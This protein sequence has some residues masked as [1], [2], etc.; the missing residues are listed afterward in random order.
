[1]PLT[2]DLANSSGFSIAI[3]DS[4]GNSEIVEGEAALQL[5]QSY[6]GIDSS[7]NIQLQDG[8][9]QVQQHVLLQPHNFILQQPS[10]T[11]DFLTVPDQ[12]PTSTNSALH[13]FPPPSASSQVHAKNH[14]VEQLGR[15]NDSVVASLKRKALSN[16]K[17]NQKSSGGRNQKK[18]GDSNKKNKSASSKTADKNNTSK[19]VVPNLGRQSSEQQFNLQ[20][21]D[22]ILKQH[23]QPTN[24]NTSNNSED[25]GSN[26]FS[27]SDL[28]ASTDGDHSDGGLLTSG[29]DAVFLDQG[30]LILQPDLSENFM[31][32]S[33]NFISSGVVSSDCQTNSA[34][35]QPMEILLDQD[36]L[37]SQSSLTSALA[38]SQVAGMDS[39]TISLPRNFMFD[40]S[41]PQLV[42]LSGNKDGNRQ[43]MLQFATIPQV[44]E[45]VSCRV[46][47]IN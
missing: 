27:A 37:H 45:V 14:D 30:Y 10:F 16:K 1:M 35:L 5:L 7:Q 43:Q 12:C 11:E 6:F 33:D 4:N 3:T 23:Q 13:L 47:Y 21:L 31:T 26:M 20:L 2:L 44:D 25:N 40:N 9:Q 17:G 36:K 32:S 18:V 24:N 41:V 28:L 15:R 46:I 19:L 22:D 8:D 29:V 39:T 34:L 42:L 38:P